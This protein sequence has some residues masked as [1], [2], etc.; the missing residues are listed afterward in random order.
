MS[1]EL[2]SRP[3]LFRRAWHSPGLLLIAVGILLGVNFPLGK[4]AMA[5]GISPIVWS[6]MISAGGALV[7]CCAVLALRLPVR[8]DWNHLRY[9]GVV[10]IVS[11]AFPNVLVYSLIPKVGSGYVAIFFTLSPMFT[12]ALSLLARLRRPSGLELCGVAVGFAGALMVASARGQA[13]QSVDW[14]WAVVGLLVPLSL[15]VGNVYRTLDWPPAANLL[16]LAV[17]SNAISAACLIVLAVLT[18]DAQSAPQLLAVPGLMVA[19]VA[20]SALMFALF[21]R[22]QAIGGPVTLSQIGTVAAAVGVIIGTAGLGERYAL[23][24]WSGVAV[25]AVGISLTLRARLKG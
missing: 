19:Q 5:A 18:G 25:I 22:L 23:I 16:W 12:V 3:G 24:V 8:F 15:A 13:G 21:F 7:L 2:A 6:A 17:G 10:A 4:L 9:F 14:L 11:Y 20:A 1:L